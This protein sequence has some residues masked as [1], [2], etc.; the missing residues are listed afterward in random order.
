MK[1][2]ATKVCKVAF[3]N[4]QLGYT[5]LHRAAA[6]GHI[7]V[8]RVLTEAGC[9]VDN[10]DYMVRMANQRFFFLFGINYRHSLEL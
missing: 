8:V 6:Q 10:Q 5:A 4:F 9:Y 2:T 7:D 3:F 1:D